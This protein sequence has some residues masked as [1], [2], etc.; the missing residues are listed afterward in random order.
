MAWQS[1]YSPGGTS[2]NVKRP[3]TVLLAL[4]VVNIAIIGPEPLGN[5]SET[6][7]APSPSSR[8]MIG[9]AADP[10][11]VSN[12]PEMRA[13]GMGLSVIARSMRSS[14]LPTAIGVAAE[15]LAAAGK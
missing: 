7:A 15:A 11:G 6:S 14:P 10:S 3:S 8:S 12:R 2:K 13:A 5:P 1:T 4:A 9:G